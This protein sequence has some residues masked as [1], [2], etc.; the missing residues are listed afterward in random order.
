M[1]ETRSRRLVA[2]SA[3]GLSSTCDNLDVLE[4]PDDGGSNKE[5]VLHAVGQHIAL[6]SV[7]DGELKVSQHN[8]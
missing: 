1:M 3:L 8:M 4:L 5:H 2:L 6:L 7:E